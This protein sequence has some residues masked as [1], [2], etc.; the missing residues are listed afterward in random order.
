M[1]KLAG[2][3]TS[4]SVITKAIVSELSTKDLDA[5]II[6]EESLIENRCIHCLCIFT[7]FLRRRDGV[8]WQV[9]CSFVR[10]FVRQC[11]HVSFTKYTIMYREQTAGPRSAN[12][13]THMHVYNIR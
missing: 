5:G 4:D 2:F 7:P 8:S 1:G 11:V 12:F 9:V 10:L 3:R 13:C 6:L